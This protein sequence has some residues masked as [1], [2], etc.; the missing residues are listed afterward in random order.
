M[1][2][3]MTANENRTYAH[4]DYAA[5]CPG[6][7]QANFCPSSAHN[8]MESSDKSEN[9]HYDDDIIIAGNADIEQF[10][11]FLQKCPNNSMY[12]RVYMRASGDLLVFRPPN[13]WQILAQKLL[14]EA[15]RDALVD[16]GIHE[17]EFAFLHREAFRIGDKVLKEPSG[18]IRPAHRAPTNDVFISAAHNGMK[19]PTIVFEV[20]YANESLEMMREIQNHWMSPGTDV[21]LAIGFKIWPNAD[22]LSVLMKSS[23]GPSRELVLNKNQVE[24]AEEVEYPLGDVWDSAF[25]PDSSKNMMLKI[26]IDKIFHYLDQLRDLEM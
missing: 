6:L 19:F 23:K 12:R 3:C 22:A 4:F 25:L 16:C 9:K 1:L 15:L 11:R 17:S 21:R 7:T 2:I 24:T 10:H 26:P 5:R 20:A 13:K 14:E 18:G 8:H